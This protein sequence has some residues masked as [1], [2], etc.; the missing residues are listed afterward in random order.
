MDETL[1]TK[2]E[3][4]EIRCPIGFTVKPKR[5]EAAFTECGHANCYPS[6]CDRLRRLGI[7]MCEEGKMP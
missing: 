3:Q 5:T 7:Q 6:A 1:Q 2:T 4:T